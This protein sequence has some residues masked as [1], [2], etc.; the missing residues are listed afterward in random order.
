M[1]IAA[2][3]GNRRSGTPI[4]CLTSGVCRGVAHMSEQIDIAVDLG[5]PP[6]LQEPRTRQ[7]VMA[8]KGKHGFF[9]CHLAPWFLQPLPQ[10]RE[11]DEV[12]LILRFDTGCLKLGP[13]GSPR[14]PVMRLR[15]APAVASS[16]ARASAGAA[17]HRRS[18]HPRFHSCFAQ[19]LV[20]RLIP[21]RRWR[22][23]AF[24]V[25]QWGRCQYEG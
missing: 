7:L 23:F 8:F 16:S 4:Y 5:V 25:S 6:P 24:I 14:P 19:G 2:V 21:V 12:H 3:A 18:E 13:L 22:G 11:A 1:K 20:S 17:R 9:G 15:T 10:S